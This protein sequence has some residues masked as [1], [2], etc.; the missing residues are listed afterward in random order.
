MTL[1]RL[2]PPICGCV[3]AFAISI[4]VFGTPAGRAGEVHQTSPRPPP[5]A[6]CLAWRTHIRDLLDQHRLSDDLND[7][8]FDEVLRLVLDAEYAC[9]TGHFTEGLTLYEAIPIGRVSSRP[10]K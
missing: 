8:Q 6:A 10:L 9:S 1:Q 2:L 3:Q 5:S 7:V 4:L